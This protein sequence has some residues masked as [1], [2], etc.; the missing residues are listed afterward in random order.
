MQ[1]QKRLF[2]PREV[3]GEKKFASMRFHSLAR[4]SIFKF[5]SFLDPDK[6]GAHISISNFSVFHLI[7]IKFGTGADVGLKT[8]WNEFE[9]ATAIF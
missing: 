7:L 9:I 2:Y 5:P 4:S 8:T 6:R 1:P 3:K